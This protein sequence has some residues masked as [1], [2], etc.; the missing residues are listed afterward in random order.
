MEKI[1]FK[2]SEVIAL[3]AEINGT[4]NAQTGQTIRKG[5][6]AQPL[7]GARKYWLK[8]LSDTL[9]KEVKI[10]NDCKEE[11]IKK[12]GEED[13]ELGL[14]IKKYLDKEQTKLN[15]NHEKYQEEMNAMLENEVEIE[16]API[17]LSEL[18]DIKFE[19]YYYY[20]FSLVQE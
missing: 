7:S 10:L 16:Y 17:P 13:E 4:I 1:K 6:M 12:Y 19:E 15:P 20:I 5:L 2:L 3:E 8:K 14:S 11:L 9:S 18:S